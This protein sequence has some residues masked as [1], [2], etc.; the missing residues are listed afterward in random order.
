MRPRIV[1]AMI[2]AGGGHKNAA[3]A[4][5]ESL[6]QLYPGRFA[7]EILDFA[8]A[9]GAEA[10]DKAHKRMWASMLKW[11][12]FTR[13]AYRLQDFGGAL[14][15]AG[16]KRWA[17]PFIEAAEQWMVR[18]EPELLVATHF[19]N[20]A[21]AVEVK[22]RRPQ[23]KTKVIHFFVEPFH[24]SSLAIW[25]DVDLMIVASEKVHEQAL[26]RGMDPQRLVQTSYPVRPSFSATQH[27][28]A[29]IK[30]QLGLAPDSLTLLMSA[31]AE[32]LGRL[33]ALAH[34]LIDR[35]LPLNV[36]VVCGRNGELQHE[37]ARRARSCGA[38]RL[39]SLGYVTNMSELITSADLV[40]AKAGPASVFE[41]LL[42][43]TPPILFDS[44]ATH[45]R[46]NARFVERN[47]LGWYAPSRRCFSRL[48]QQIIEEPSRL[49][50]ARDRIAGMGLKNGA[51][52]SARVIARFLDP[53]LQ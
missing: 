26:R 22:R 45:E 40:A 35:D 4:M 5:A 43:G 50:A 6:E 15:R 39:A 30:K 38:L 10:F 53:R 13:M 9:V 3:Q 19:L 34:A 24:L 11:P 37:L 28:P 29:E 16:I 1:F 33:G 27:E 52:P 41:A 23:L 47:G 44:V 17:S 18:E 51:Q 32:G 2:E 48:L 20:A 49:T 42:L 46:E 31:G 14:T 25:R 12:V 21:V 8:T 7:L 36:I